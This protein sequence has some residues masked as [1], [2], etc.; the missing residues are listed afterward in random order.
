MICF[1]LISRE[2]PELY[3][4]ELRARYSEL[5]DRVDQRK[6]QKLNGGKTNGNHNSSG[7][8]GRGERLNAAQKERMRLLTSAAFDRG[9]GE[10]T[11]GTRDEDWLVYKKMSKD[12]DDDDDGNDDD[13]SELARIASKIQVRS[14]VQAILL[15]SRDGHFV[16]LRS[17][18]S[19]VSF[20]IINY[21]MLPCAG[22]GPYICEQ[23]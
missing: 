17:H 4:E 20:T 9:K 5:S 6:R 12:N 13:E 8:V 18:T 2:N 7:G 3:L 23:S 10:D 15:V 22:Y 11:F 21:L 16:L 19:I 1:T 14:H